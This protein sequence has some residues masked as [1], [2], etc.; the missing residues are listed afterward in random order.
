M[1][2]FL[3]IRRRFRFEFAVADRRATSF[4]AR[5]SPRRVSASI[6]VCSPQRADAP[7]H[8]DR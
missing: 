5:R 6:V 1:V 4:L 2:V 7:E 3:S 8:G